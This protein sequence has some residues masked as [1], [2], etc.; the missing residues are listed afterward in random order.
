MPIPEKTDTSNTVP[1]QRY[2]HTAVNFI[3]SAYIWG[4]RNDN[5]GACNILFAF[6]MSKYIT[7]HYYPNAS[8]MEAFL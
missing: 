2:G 6:D 3:D 4:G 7:I 8:P 1:Y 5:D